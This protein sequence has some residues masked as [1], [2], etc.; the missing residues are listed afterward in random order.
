MSYTYIWQTTECFSWWCF[1]GIATCIQT[2]RNQ[3][4]KRLNRSRCSCRMVL[5]WWDAAVLAEGEH[6]FGTTPRLDVHCTGREKGKESPSHLWAAWGLR[7]VAKPVSEM[8]PTSASPC[9]QSSWG[10]PQV[11]VS[12]VMG[13]AFGGKQAHT[14][15]EFGKKM[16]QR[17]A[18]RL[19][20]ALS[21][22][23]ENWACLK[24]YKYISAE[25]EQQVIAA[26]KL[27][28]RPPTE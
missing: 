8:L 6:S 2:D 14:Y 12:R 22:F 11:T 9:S 23:F 4:I 25:D 24:P 13:F 19:V 5:S 15:K 10:F 21:S 3:A 1:H 16:E 28:E 17:Q 7:A 27:E 26:I 18:A 20:T